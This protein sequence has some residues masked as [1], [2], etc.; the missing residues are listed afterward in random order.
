MDFFEEQARAQRVTGSLLFYFGLGALGIAFMTC[1]CLG[2][3]LGLFLSLW[4][5]FWKLWIMR[6]FELFL[7]A[8]GG[9][10]LLLVLLGAAWKTRRLKAGGGPAVAEALGGR[11]ITPSEREPRRRRLLNVVEEM[12]LAAGL[13]AP[14]VY[15]LEEEQGINAFA[16]G[17]QPFFAVVGVTRGALELLERDE[18]QAVVAHEF[19]HILYGDMLLNTRLMGLAHGIGLIG[20]LGRKLFYSSVGATPERGL[21]SDS[22]ANKV[23]PPGAALGL[24]LLFV[25]SIGVF[26]SRLMQAAVCRQRE[27]LAD[28]AAVQ[29]TRDPAAL[30]SA[31]QKIGGLN[32]GARLDSPQAEL[33]S[34]IFF[35]ACR[36]PF[37]TRLLATHPPLEERILRID[38]FWEGALPPLDPELERLMARVSEQAQAEIVGLVMDFAGAPRISAQA[39]ASDR[40]PVGELSPEAI[41]RG[42]ALLRRLPAKILAAARAPAKAPALLYALLLAGASKERQAELDLLLD[43]TD[44]AVYDATQALLPELESLPFEA[45]IPLLDQ[46][47]AAL[48]AAGP[49]PAQE[50]LA[51]LKALAAADRRLGLFEW[52]LLHILNRRIVRYF[53]P[54]KDKRPRYFSFDPLREACQDALSVLA[55]S[56]ARAN[57]TAPDTGKANAAFAAGAARLPFKDLSLAPEVSLKTLDAALRRLDQAAPQ[58]KRPLVE[59]CAACIAAPRPQPAFAPELIRAVSEALG[60]PA[61]LAGG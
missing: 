16:A 5:P 17:F 18:L 24:A 4:P 14:V 60:C 49:A 58:L 7:L 55:W 42:R 53:R 13:P 40:L 36:T 41:E 19:S 15:A 1:L 12:S 2:L 29:F 26:F 61:S 44:V 34:H 39:G 38:P 46:A 52:T 35:G 48:R 32:K 45:R 47:I 37:L 57:G 33:V 27:F 22:D 56:V 20:A 30:S 51:T 50:C 21:A 25:G 23:F 6:E 9:L 28:A 54:I 10:T 59:A 43:R 8:L 11:Q 3:T 31:L